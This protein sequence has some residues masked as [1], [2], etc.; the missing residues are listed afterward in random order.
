[1]GL[2]DVVFSNGW[3]LKVSSHVEMVPKHIVQ[4]A[5]NLIT[6]WRGI[7]DGGSTWVQGTHGVPSLV[8]RLDCVIDA[9]GNLRLFE[10]EERPCG[11]GITNTLVPQFAE[12]LAH[13][14][15]YEWPEFQWVTHPD[16]VTDDEEWLG[17]G[18]SLDEAKGAEGLLLVRSRPEDRAYHVLESRAVSTVSREGIKSYGLDMGLWREIRWV[19]DSSE[20]GGGYVSPPVQG[21]LVVKPLRGTRCNMVKVYLNLLGKPLQ[22]EM[23]RLLCTSSERA[24]LSGLEAMVRAGPGGRAYVQP[25]VMPM[26]RSE[27]PDMNMILRLYF[28][29]APSSNTFEPMHGMWMARRAL[30]VHGQD[31]ALFGSAICED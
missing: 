26:R 15:Q 22:K 14:R 21:P 18:L 19:E 12:R 25:L 6:Q 5:Q 30:L 11:I 24:S 16:R 29:F 7:Y 9:G 31:G 28:G 13:F 10:V 17:P 4:R 27:V 3:N 2:Q 23:Q 20:Q 8:I 1:M